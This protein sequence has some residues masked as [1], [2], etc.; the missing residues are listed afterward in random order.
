MPMNPQILASI[1]Q[2]SGK[3]ASYIVSN[4]P[5]RLKP[6]EPAPTIS[7]EIL[8]EPITVDATVKESKATGIEA[9]CLPC[10]IGHTGTCSGLLNEAVRFAKGEDGVKSLEVIDRVSMCLDE[11]N[12][13]ERVDLRPEQIVDLPPWQKTLANKALDTSR[14]TRHRLEG[15]KSVEDLEQAAAGLQVVR[16]EIGRGW[17]QQR[18]SAGTK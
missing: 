2:I 5:I 18:P 3:I 15:L 4:R 14:S 10:A 12:A 6:A 1:V 17:F 16:N 9:G 11:L 7:Q 8:P 13:L